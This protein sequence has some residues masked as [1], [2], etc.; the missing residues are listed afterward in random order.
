MGDYLSQTLKKCVL[1]VAEA[2]IQGRPI[3]P[4]TEENCAVAIRELQERIVPPQPLKLEAKDVAK[5]L[6]KPTPR[7]NIL[8]KRKAPPPLGQERL[9]KALSPEQRQDLLKKLRGSNP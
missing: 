6:P 2:F 1:G 4:S 5:L 8:S 7:D 3:G 9:F